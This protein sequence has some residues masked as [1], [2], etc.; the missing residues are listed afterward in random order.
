MAN[1]HGHCCQGKQATPSV[2]Q[3]LDEM[4]F[5]RGLWTAALNDDQNK[6]KL[7]LKSGGDP[8]ALDSSG[9]TALHYASRAGHV[10][11]CRLLLDYGCCINQGTRSGGSTAL[12]RA[13]GV[14]RTDV[15]KL[16]LQRGADILLQ[17]E[18]GQSALH[19]AAQNAHKEVIGLLVKSKPEAKSIKD[20]RDRLARDL[21]ARERTDLL[22]LLQ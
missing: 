17:D 12:L 10:E 16:L 15:V 19:K 20:K 3:T 14:G 8:N 2:H 11:T 1:H 21:V 6:V 4:E 18:D 9:Y 22:Q 13:A 5:E 7:L